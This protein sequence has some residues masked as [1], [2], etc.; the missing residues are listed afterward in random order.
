M[1]CH[2]ISPVRVVALR[3]LAR[4]WILPYRRTLKTTL[5]TYDRPRRHS[6]ACALPRLRNLLPLGRYPAV[7]CLC[8]VMGDAPTA[9]IVLPLPA[10]G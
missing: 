9:V 5:S 6:S 7:Q 1:A 2:S 4:R 8:L 3:L 10:G